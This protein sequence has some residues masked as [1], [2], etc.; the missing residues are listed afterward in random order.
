M[1]FF[2]AVR[3]LPVRV[4][5]ATG[6][7]ARFAGSCN[8]CGTPANKIWLVNIKHMQV[9]LCSKCRKELVEQLQEVK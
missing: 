6:D 9:R 1:D 8:G 2:A 4:G 3:E 5:L 7:Q